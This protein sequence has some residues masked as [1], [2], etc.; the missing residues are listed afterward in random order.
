MLKKICKSPEIYLIYVPLPN[1]PLKNLNCYVMK[2][3]AGN[4]IIDTGFNQKECYTAL[5]IGLQELN[6]NMDRTTL[7]LT[8]LHSDHV[9]LVNKIRTE[10]TRIIMGDIDYKYLLDNF[11]G[12]NWSYFD[13]RYINE[14]F[15]EE[16][17]K[18]QKEL[19]PAVIYEPEKIFEAITINDGQSFFISDYEFECILTSG[20]TPG[21]M[22]LYLKN[23]KIMFLG[24]H[25]LFDITPNITAWPHIDNSLAD[26]FESLDKIKKY[27]IKLALPAHRNNGIVYDRIEQIKKHH[28][29]RLEDTFNIVKNEKDIN[30]YEVASKLKWSLRAK[31]WNECPV[32]QKWFAVGEAIAHLDYLSEQKKIVKEKKD[33]FTVYNVK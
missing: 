22:C 33:N 25:V 29:E 24:D 2:T 14:G 20:H 7:F 11:N 30:A 13:K 9:G 23:E 4:L 15:P 27:D 21:H 17:L 1:N 12:E 18:K 8:H 16:E 19:N 3:E 28:D 32:Q 5:E 6:I 10:K 31:S 26:Y